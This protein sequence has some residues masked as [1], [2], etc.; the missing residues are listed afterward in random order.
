MTLTVDNP[1]L[2][3]PYREPERCWLYDAAGV[4][5]FVS[6]SQPQTPIVCLGQNRQGYRMPRPQ[7]GHHTAWSRISSAGSRSVR[8]RWSIVRSSEINLWKLKLL[9]LVLTTGGN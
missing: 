1:I 4:L 3:S 5:L 8:W 2:N 9:P 7:P 6:S